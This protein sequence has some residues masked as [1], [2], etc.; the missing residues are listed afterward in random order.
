MQPGE[1]QIASIHDVEQASLPSQLVEDVHIVDAAG[2]DNDDG[3]KVALEREQCVEFDGGLAPTERGPREQREAQVN[4]GG[5]QRVGGG[6]EF[7]AEGFASVERGRLT[8]EGVGEV[9][10]D[11]PV[12]F[13][14][15]IGQRAA[16]GGL[17]DA[18]VIEL[19]AEG[20]QTGFDVA[21]TFAPGQLRES[22]NEKL[23]VGGQF[24]DAEVAA[25]TGDT[26]VEL[27]FGEEVQELGE[28]SA[29]F[30]HRVENRW[31]AV[32]HPRKLVVKLKS[33]KARTVKERR[34][35]RNEII[36]R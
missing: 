25:V 19:R 33:K 13:F 14:V 21:Q 11:A 20:R 3:G 30:V 6:L 24:A 28:D 26:L 29:T 16:G 27:V 2:R 22:Q 35:Y 15:G 32:N 7:D 17:A 5:V 4:G 18:R 9:G 1:V 36:V 10:K 31:I 12:A 23:F 34:F 8:D